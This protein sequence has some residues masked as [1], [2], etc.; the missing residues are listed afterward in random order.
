MAIWIPIGLLVLG[1]LAI[2]LEVFIPAGGVL[3]IIG[4][5]LMILS[6]VLAYWYHQ[7]IIGTIFLGASIIGTPIAFIFSLKI[8]PK[9]FFGKKLILSQSETQKEGF[10]SY[11]EARY[12]DLID[13]EGVAFT[14]LRPAGMIKIENKKYNVVTS[15][16]YIDKD[17]K[18]K[19]IKVEGSRIIVKKL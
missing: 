19:V 15:G 14:T 7:A 6:T 2:I 8:F 4:L 11:T 17:S 13:K 9:T 5:I 18:V 12:T 10:V 1:I 3:G 16:E